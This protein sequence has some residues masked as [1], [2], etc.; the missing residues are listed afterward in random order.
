MSCFSFQL[1]MYAHPI[2]SD[3]GDYPSFVRERI[4]DMSRMQGYSRSRLPYFTPEEVRIRT[5]Y[6]IL[7]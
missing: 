4:N 7:S 5:R 3:I 6:K 2:F 1:G